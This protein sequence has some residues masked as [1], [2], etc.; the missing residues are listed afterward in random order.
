MK[1]LS[2][3][4]RYSK[5]PK[6]IYN[7]NRVVFGSS[8]HAVLVRLNERRD[9]RLYRITQLVITYLDANAILRVNRSRMKVD[10]TKVSFVRLIVGYLCR[11]LSAHKRG[12]FNKIENIMIS[13]TDG[14]RYRVRF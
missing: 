2:Y 11:P 3:S 7:T 9:A 8:S 10:R 13:G 1:Y 14:A 6:L 5:I 12:G 4:D